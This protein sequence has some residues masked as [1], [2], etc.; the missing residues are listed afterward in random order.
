MDFKNIFGNVSNPYY[1]LPPVLSYLLKNKKEV[2]NIYCNDRKKFYDNLIGYGGFIADVL[3]IIEKNDKLL[4]LRSCMIGAKSGLILA[5][6]LGYDVHAK[7]DWAFI[8]AAYNGH[9]DVCELLLK[10]GADVTA[11]HDNAFRGAAYYGHKDV[12]ELLLEHG[13]DVH[14]ENDYALIWAAYYGHVSVCKILLEHGADV[15][16]RNNE[17]LRYA[18]KNGHKDVCKILKKYMKK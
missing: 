1:V 16:A 3:S 13:A 18:I 8:E 12:C 14:A 9:K 11:F 17:A 7:F 2:H 4:L 10:Y 15:H 5:L 6:F